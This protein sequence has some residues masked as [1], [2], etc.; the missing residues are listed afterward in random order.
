MF[1]TIMVHVDGL[2][3]T[4]ARTRLAVALAGKFD[5]TLIGFSATALRLPLELYD[6]ALGTVALGPDSA[7]VDRGAVEAEFARDKAAFQQAAKGTR[8]ETDWREA[9]EEPGVAII[10][11]ATVAD[12]IV[13]GSG[14][15]TLLGNLNA[16]DVGDVVLHTG[17]P[18]LVVPAR[19]AGTASGTSIVVAWKNTPQ[20]QRALSDALP[21]MK[22]A[23]KV[24]LLSV[25]EK[26][27][28]D[29]SLA[30]AQGFLV[31]HGIAATTEA[32]VRGKASVEDEIIDF[33]E[34]QKADLIVSG[35][36][37]HTRLREWAFGGVTRGLLDRSP[38]PCLFSH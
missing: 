17:R 24:V 6:A 10:A 21:F 37:G 25:Q 38:V 29:S 9:F 11:A 15:H 1:R 30:D 4:A 13:L 19:Y 23:A 2:E 20:S 35:A 33:V 3:G 22:S 7:E 8:L 14:D 27:G 16:P 28:G 34:R 5:A 36:Y 32:R 26:G 12:L 31:R 18:L